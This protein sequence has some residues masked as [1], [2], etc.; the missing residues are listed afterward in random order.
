MTNLSISMFTMNNTDK[1][2]ADATDPACLPHPSGPGH[3]PR[4]GGPSRN[5]RGRPAS[6][7]TAASS[8]RDRTRTKR[9]CGKPGLMH[10]GVLC[11]CLQ[12]KCWGTWHLLWVWMT[13]KWPQTMSEPFKSCLT[14]VG[15]FQMQ[16][17]CIK[18][19]LKSGFGDC[20]GMDLM[21]LEWVWKWFF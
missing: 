14:T 10:Y 5:P 12:N 18:I 11:L 21:W 6:N 9:T 1:M 8:S 4:G 19:D 16:L 3:I 15:P 20:C 7:P 2:M 13:S 17:E